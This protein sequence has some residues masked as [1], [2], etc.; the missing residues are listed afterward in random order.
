MPLEE[1]HDVIERERPEVQLKASLKEIGDLKAA[2][3]EHAIV[4]ITDP[5]GKITYVNDKF[6]SI[7]K[8]SREELLGQDHRLINSGHHPEVFIRELWS[9][10]TRGKVWKG[11]IKNRAKDGSFYWVDTTIVPFLNEQGKPRQY[12]A[13]RADITERKRAEEELTASLKEVGDLK[14]ALD[15]HAIVAI[16]DPQGKITYVNDKFCSISKYSREE[17]LGQ[18]HRLINSGHHPEVF[19]RELWSTIT[20]GKVW[21]GEIKNRAKDGSFYWVDTTIVPFL[22]EQGKPRQYVAIR[23]DITERKRAEAAFRESEELFSKAFRLSP[24]CVA[25]TRLSDRTVIR[26]NEAL[27]RLWGSTA[28]D[29]IGKPSREYA[30]WQ[31]EE[32]QRAFMETLHQHG[33]CLNYD[34]VLRMADGR[35]LNFNLSS[36]LISFNEES[37]VLSVMRDITERK[38]LARAMRDSEERFRTMAN[39]IP[40]LAWIARADGFIYWYNQRWYEYT[41]TTPEQ[42]EG[43][44][45]QSVHDPVALPQVMAQWQAA[46]ATGQPLEME[47]P[48]RAADGRFR[49]FL[50]RVQPM[51]DAQG[52]VVQWFG[53]NTDVDELKRM[54]ASLRATQTRLNSTLAAGSIGTWSWDLSSDRLVA[55]QFTARAFSIHP[56]EAAKGLPAAAYL[57]AVAV[58]DRPGVSAALASAIQ[59]CGSYDIEYRVRRD[60]ELLWLQARGRVEGDATGKAMHFHGAVMDITARKLAE[61]EVRQS[62]EYFRF[63]NDLVEATRT[64]ADPAQIMAVM[65][66]MLGG[67]LQASR[68][69][70]ADVEADGE[71]FT[72]LHDY[73]D[74]CL[75]TVGRYQLSRFGARAVATLRAGKTLIIRDVAAELLPEDGAAMF[76]AIGIQAIITCPLVKDGVL[77]ALMAVHQTTPRDWQPGEI[78]VVQDVVERCWAT[79]ERRAAE[80]K[81]HRL[82]AEL[83]LRVIERTAQLEAANK[84]LESF[85][86][87]VSHDLRSPLRGIDGFSRTLMDE[88]ADVLDETGRNYLQRIRAATQRMGQL[89]DDLL[90]LA[91]VTRSEMRRVPV[92]LTAQARLIAQELRDSQPQREAEF[93]I[94]P[95][96]T[97]SADPV[98][99]RVVLM[100]LLG[101]AWKF[102]GR[103]PHTHIEVGSLVHEGKPVFLVR[104]NGAGFDMTYADKLFAPFQRLHPQRE[105]PGTGIGLATVHRIVHRHGGRIWAESRVGQ[106]A[107]FYFSLSS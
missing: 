54:E 81:I 86:Y 104:D 51:K 3:D 58:E 27:C 18:D 22:N 24:D 100:N 107:T 49:T 36:R 35:L 56:D 1:A 50:T 92:D 45:W 91:R 93:L 99:L 106:G 59:S 17:L 34:T 64:L 20:R 13:I 97:T 31:T 101:N 28:E 6:C 78:G 4:A 14:A 63:L 94:A 80:E 98:L 102:T 7:S 21:K 70:Y 33:E 32:E 10:I 43:W 72:I 48:L 38:E 53:T 62:E 103:Q 16:T 12:V 67:H 29:V 88:Y 85:S 89:I 74:G 8:Y 46:I 65:A 5:Q 83:E 44:G 40:Q 95:G 77:C 87:S 55:D 71:Q 15:E 37:C 61:A 30:T 57:A 23:A 79:I 66:R 9:T 68:C 25:I 60:G 52:G 2:L 69:A 82:N 39:S 73:T 105:F 96:L 76:K 47:F 11:E 90:E 26:A 42:M 75:S 41:G 19:I 84:E